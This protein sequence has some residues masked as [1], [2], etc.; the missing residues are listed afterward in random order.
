MYYYKEQIKW[1]CKKRIQNW[2]LG[3][4]INGGLSLLA[5]KNA[6]VN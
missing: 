4:K 2:Y 6:M 1:Y 3:S 5:F